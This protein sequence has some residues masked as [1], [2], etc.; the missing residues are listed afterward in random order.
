MTSAAHDVETTAADSSF[1]RLVV[2]S[3][4]LPVTIRRKS[5]KLDVVPSV[6]GL[7]AAMEPAMRERGGLWIGWPGAKVDA[8]ETLEM[9]GAPYRLRPIPLSSGEVQRYYHGFSNGALWPLFHSLPD[10]ISLDPR[11]YEVYERV[12]ERFAQAAIEEL[13][14]GDLVWVHDY[15][16]ML[17]PE[18]I[19]RRRPDVRIAMFLHIPFPPFDVYRVLPSYRGIL[20]GMLACD[21][22]GFHCPGYVRNFEDSVERLLGARVD[23]EAGRIEHGD[24]TIRVGAFPLGIDYREY[25][26][27]AWDAPRPKRSPGEKIILGV[28]RLDYTK[29][30]PERLRA[31]ERLLEQHAEHRGTTSL[32][33]IAVPSREQVSEYK[34]LKRELDELV[35]RINGRFGTSLWTPIRYLHRSIPAARLSALYRDAA[36]GLVTPLRDGMNLVAKEFV[37]SQTDDPGVLVLSRLAG[38]AETMKEALQVNPYNIESVADALHTALTMA[39]ADREER[40]LSLQRREREHDLDAWLR[41]FLAEATR[42]ADRMAPVREADFEAW[43]SPFVGA[44][45]LA[46]FLDFDGTLVRIASHPAMVQLGT[47]MQSLLEACVARPDT[48]V[49]IISGRSLEDLRKHVRID[50]IALAG[51]H[52]LEIEG[53]GLSDYRHPD[54]EHYEERAH[55]LARQ[56]ETIRSD[57]AWVEQKGASLTFHFRSVAPEHH[58]KIAEEARQ[59]IQDAG[60]QP[61]DALCAVEGRPP[62]GW[63]KGRAVLHLLREKYGPG[64]SEKIRVIY[65]GDDETDEDA[66]GSLRGLGS[67]FRVGPATRPTLARRRLSDV[68][69][70]GTM[71]RWITRRRPGRPIAEISERD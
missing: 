9:P 55:E 56:L 44:R 2:L 32:V 47:E 8:D 62:I 17:C 45:S 16:L 5:G 63:D 18:F 25:E 20:R 54:V 70:V 46:V 42:P 27:R 50:G 30:I 28:D 29:G 24:Q 6:G 7:V 26:Q 21:L 15:Q 35:G 39:H 14:E 1:R 12:N 58:E 3:N 61:R 22:V 67:T 57:G 49:A 38:A 37:A 65:V 59:R 4:R 69:A 34:A 60:F 66:F 10:R 41:A 64:W 36:V 53:P 23:R 48:D 40:M 31:Y 43:L 13:E 68:E 52:G 19:R 11:N 33:Q 71:L 51:N